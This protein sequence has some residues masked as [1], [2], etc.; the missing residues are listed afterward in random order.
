VFCRTPKRP[1][2]GNLDAR[3]AYYEALSAIAE[4][5]VNGVVFGDGIETDKLVFDWGMRLRVTVSA[6]TLELVGP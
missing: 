1:S 2:A 6:K 3:V 4:D 5:P